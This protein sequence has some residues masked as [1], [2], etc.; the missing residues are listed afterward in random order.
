MYGF[1]IPLK[2]LSLDKKSQTEQ[3]S[4]KNTAEQKTTQHRSSVVSVL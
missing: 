2:A 4:Q 1:D 3:T